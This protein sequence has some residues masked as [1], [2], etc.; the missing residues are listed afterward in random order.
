M[1]CQRRLV[2]CYNVKIVCVNKM[3]FTDKTLLVIVK[4]KQY[5]REK[6]DCSFM[7]DYQ[8][9]CLITPKRRPKFN[10]S[11]LSSA[12]TDPSCVSSVASV[13]RL[14]HNLHFVSNMYQRSWYITIFTLKYALVVHRCLK[15]NLESI[16]MDLI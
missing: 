6:V 14:V 2:L 12:D 3:R 4:C 16:F 10:D 13:F 5:N 15:K 8:L 11:T 7:I 1:Y 9:F